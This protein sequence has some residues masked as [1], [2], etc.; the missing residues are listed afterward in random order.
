MVFPLPSCLFHSLL[1]PS[2]NLADAGFTYAEIDSDPVLSF[3]SESGPNPE[4]FR[5]LGCKAG[6][7]DFTDAVLK[8][9]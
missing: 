8:R 9:L 6:T 2:A 3:L 5:D 4:V 1:D 7:R